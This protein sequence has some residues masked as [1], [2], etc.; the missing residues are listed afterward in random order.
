MTRDATGRL[1]HREGSPTLEDLLGRCGD[2][3]YDEGHTVCHSTL[4]GNP[5][6]LPASVC[7]WIAQHPQAG[8]RSLVMRLAASAGTI[9]VRPPARPAGK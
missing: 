1:E 7:A 6:D 3:T 4:P 9:P 5:D 2:G 8:P